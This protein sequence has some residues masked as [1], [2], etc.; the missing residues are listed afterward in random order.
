MLNPLRAVFLSMTSILIVNGATATLPG[1]GAAMQSAVDAGEIA[2][3]V[4]VVVNRAQVLHSEATGMADL[5][6]NDPMRSD[7]VF[8]IAS[9]TKPVTAVALLMLQDEGRLDIRDPVAK[10][11]PEFEDLKTPS[12]QPAGLTLVQLMTH[13]SGLGEAEWSAAGKARTLADLIPL[14][15]SVPMQNEPG[16]RWRYCQS[17]I[18]S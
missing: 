18:T 1:V 11:I 10:Y 6:D 13:T 16:A 7:T 17:S 9:M 15:L 12:G 14:Y 8:W 3:A 4:T 2:G 5:A